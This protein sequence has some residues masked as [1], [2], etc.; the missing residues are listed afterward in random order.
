MGDERRAGALILEANRTLTA[1]IN[2]CIRTTSFA[3]G[4]LQG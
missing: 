3:R 1:L 2:F 4:V